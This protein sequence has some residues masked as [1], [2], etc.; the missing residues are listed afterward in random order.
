MAV[1][2]SSTPVIVVVA[3]VIRRGGQVLMCQ[4]PAGSRHAGLW[5]FPGGKVRMD[6]DEGSALRRELREELDLREVTIG[7]V[8]YETRDPGSPYLIRFYACTTAG[9]PTALEHQAVRWLEPEKLGALR[10]APAD[11]HFATQLTT[12]GPGA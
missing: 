6:E 1:P 9:E 2:E 5:E 11:H 7:D 3:A 4:R 8:L 12:H 10:L